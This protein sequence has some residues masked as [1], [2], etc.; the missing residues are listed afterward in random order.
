VEQ[1]EIRLEHLQAVTDHRQRL[2]TSCQMLP[3]DQRRPD[4]ED[5]IQQTMAE[6]RSLS[7]PTDTE[8]EMETSTKLMLCFLDVTTVETYH[9]M[10]VNVQPG[11]TDH[12]HRRHQLSR[13]D[14][15]MSD[16]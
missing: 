1:R 16:Q 10:L 7:H 15:R 8:I 5:S 2:G 12:R 14:N 9:T 13:R 6:Q 3:A 11:Q 4:H